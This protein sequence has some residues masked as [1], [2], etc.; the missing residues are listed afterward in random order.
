MN[1]FVC[2][3]GLCVLAL[4][5][6]TFCW[7][8]DWCRDDCGQ[9]LRP[10]LPDVKWSDPTV[11]NTCGADCTPQGPDCQ[12]CTFTPYAYNYTKTVTTDYDYVPCAGAGATNCAGHHQVNALTREVD[13]YHYPCVASTCC[14]L[15][16]RNCVF[17][18]L[19]ENLASHTESYGVVQCICGGA[20]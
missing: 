8:Q 7:A 15:P 10:P 4:S 3:V 17:M 16:D 2:C 20:S 14:D 19:M 1:R 12:P 13:T 11:C 6:M 9:Q 18:G 5:G